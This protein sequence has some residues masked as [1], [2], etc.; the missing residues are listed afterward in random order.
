MGYAHEAFDL[1][2]K[3]ANY[4]Q[5]RATELPTNPRLHLPKPC[6]LRQEV[7]MAETKAKMLEKVH[8]YLNENCVLHEPKIL[9]RNH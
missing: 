2:N 5:L 8:Q 1:E 9:H 6:P 4:K 3:T 7:A